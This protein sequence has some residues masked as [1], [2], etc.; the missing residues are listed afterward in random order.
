MIKILY[1]ILVLFMN[2]LIYKGIQDRKINKKQLLILIA[3]G[4]IV[5]SL[6]Y[7]FGSISSKLILF[8]VLFSF[9]IIILNFFKKHINVYEKSNLLNND[10]V[11][12]IKFL[13]INIIIPVMITIYQFLII[14]SDNLFYKMT[15]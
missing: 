2:L 6:N 10:K 9:S 4:I 7:K 8:L 5:V 15:K 11:E 14:W 3:Y 13:M 12:K 1:S